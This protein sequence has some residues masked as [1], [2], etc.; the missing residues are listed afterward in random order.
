MKEI[1]GQSVIVADHEVMAC[2]ES[3][4]R[5]QALIQGID[6][7]APLRTGAE[8]QKAHDVVRKV[9]PAVEADRSLAPDIEAVARLID[10]GCFSA[11][12]R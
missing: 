4:E 2:V 1:D 8:A 3:R 12:L 6:L 9:S 5:P 7:L 11:I 10:K